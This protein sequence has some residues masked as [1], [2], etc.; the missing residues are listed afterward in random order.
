VTQILLPDVDTANTISMVRPATLRATKRSAF[1]LAS[2]IVTVWAGTARIVLVLQGHV[3]AQTFSLVG[4]L[5]TNGAVRP[6]MDFLIVSVPNIIALPDIAHIAYHNRLHAISGNGSYRCK[7]V[8]IAHLNSPLTNLLPNCNFG[9][10][11]PELPLSND[12]GRGYKSVLIATQLDNR[13][14]HM[15]LLD[16]S[17]TQVLH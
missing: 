13:K 14:P 9:R 2:Y 8:E 15:L 3:H 11:I 17:I 10:E 16:A 1:D 12:Y 5:V 4:K 7:S 6:L